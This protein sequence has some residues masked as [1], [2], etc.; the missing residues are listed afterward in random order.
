MTYTYV[1]IYL[2]CTIFYL[3][4][5]IKCPIGSNFNVYFLHL[6]KTI[7]KISV[8][9]LSSNFKQFFNRTLYN[10]G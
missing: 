3:I 8:Y 7:H 5:Q 9:I 10:Y 1:D 4:L 2:V 6:F